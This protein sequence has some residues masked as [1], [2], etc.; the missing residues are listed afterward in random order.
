MVSGINQPCP[1]A[2]AVVEWAMSKATQGPANA[3]SWRAHLECIRKDAPFHAFVAAYAGAGLVAGIA[4]GVPH[5]FAPLW[6]VY[7]TLGVAVFTTVIAGGIWALRSP[8][9]CASLGRA[10]AG[11][12]HP[13]TVAA[14]LLFLSLCVHMG[15][16]TSI[17]TMLPDISPFHADR[18]LADLDELLHG[19]A[20]SRHLMALLPASAIPLVA[21]V[22]AGIWSLLLPAGLLAVLF[23][24]QLRP[25][26]AQYLWTHLLAWPVLGNLVAGTA[27]SA[28][29]V[30]YGLVTGDRVRFAELTGYL[31]QVP[32][33]GEVVG[34]LWRS[35]LSGQ[36]SFAGGISAFPSMHLVN[37]TLL[38]LLTMRGAGALRWTAIAFCAF[39]LMA[40]VRLGWHYAIDGYFSIAATVAIWLAVGGVLH[41]LAPSAGWR[42]PALVHDAMP[43]AR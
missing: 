27:M 43:S 41:Q 42:R 23:V 14:A 21:F 7:Y 37:A 19:S 32:G 30:F 36:P 31:A 26:R 25:V 20:P 22:Y 8:D 6:Y 24:P 35:H 28:G 33:L 13:G 9:P 5:K 38:V 12:V 11:A 40:S 4:A 29:P 39:I 2:G 16:F 1:R 18:T 34:Y 15:V 3:G 10:A 17:K